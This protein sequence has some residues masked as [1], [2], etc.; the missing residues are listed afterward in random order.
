MT[1]K[2][3]PKTFD[4]VSAFITAALMAALLF[5][6]TSC[7]RYSTCPTYAASHEVKL[8]GISEFYYPNGKREIIIRDEHYNLIAFKDTTNE[9][10]I[11][12]ER[13]LA[14]IML[15]IIK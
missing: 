2:N 11:N 4:Y 8:K 6:L 1:T 3:T 14:E 5:F 7:N 13:K 10:C 15:D 9:W 12:S